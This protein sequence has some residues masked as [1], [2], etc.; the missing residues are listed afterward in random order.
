MFKP[1]NLAE[2]EKEMIDFADLNA[3]VTIAFSLTL[4][5]FFLGYIALKVSERKPTRVK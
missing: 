5:A 2:E 3:K 1:C 4:I